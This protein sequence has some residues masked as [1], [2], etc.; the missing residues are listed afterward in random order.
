MDVYQLGAQRIAARLREAGKPANEEGIA[1]ALRATV[2]AVQQ[3][4]PEAIREEDILEAAEIGMAV[5][6]A[7]TAHPEL[8]T[9]KKG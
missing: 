3:V 4:L 2:R 1:E 8:S 9:T 6:I 5:A 7:K